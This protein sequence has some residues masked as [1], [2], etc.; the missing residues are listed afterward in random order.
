M[1]R[2]FPFAMRRFFPFATLSLTLAACDQNVSDRPLPEAAPAELS[3]LAERLSQAPSLSVPAG[4]TIS[5][6]IELAPRLVDLTAPTDVVYVI[7]RDPAAD[8]PPVAVQRLTGNSYPMRFVL[9][10]TGAGVSGIPPVPVQLVVKVDEDGDVGTSADTDL[11]GFTTEVIP[12]GAAGVT[13]EVEATMGEVA[14][15][16]RRELA[17]ASGQGPGRELAPDSGQAG[18]QSISGT[19]TL[20][21]A[22][23][24]RTSDRDVLFVI[25]RDPGAAGPPVAVARLSGNRYPIAFSLAAANRMLAGEWPEMVMLEARLDRDGDPLTR[26]PEDLAGRASAPVRPGATGVRIELGG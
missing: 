19:I 1:L 11:L 14:Q 2:F 12:P 4:A 16:A 26:G 7:A 23:R 13:I 22:L 18:G 15:A 10:L 21:P 20:A 25:A 24:S 5:G 3:R 6:S 17:P 8:G 9:D